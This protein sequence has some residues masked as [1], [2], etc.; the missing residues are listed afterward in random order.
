MLKSQ[1]THPRYLHTALFLYKLMNNIIMLQ[2]VDRKVLLYI[3]LGFPYI[4]C[5]IR[6]INANRSHCICFVRKYRRAGP[7]IPRQHLPSRNRDTLRKWHVC[8]CVYAL[9]EV[10]VAAQIAVGDTTHA[11]TGCKYAPAFNVDIGSPMDVTWMRRLE[12]TAD[13]F[14][15]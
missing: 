10:V 3:S 8:V 12:E 7:G 6:A 2:N 5:D 13:T 4:L 1:F 15:H 11:Y 14:F 9:N